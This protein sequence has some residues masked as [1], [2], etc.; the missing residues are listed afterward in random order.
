MEYSAE[1]LSN[2]DFNR[3]PKFFLNFS[4]LQFFKVFDLL[5]PSALKKTFK[6]LSIFL[7]ISNTIFKIVNKTSENAAQAKIAF[8]KKNNKSI[9]SIKIIF[10]QITNRMSKR[11]WKNKNKVLELFSSQGEASRIKSRKR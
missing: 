4:T 2:L 8:P 9:D 1:K 11:Q 6:F 7:N 5:F 10:I 3:S